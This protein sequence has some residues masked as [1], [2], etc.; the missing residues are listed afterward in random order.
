M[1]K[2]KILTKITKC[3]QNVFYVYEYSGYVQR[4]KVKKIT[5][6][7]SNKIDEKVIKTDFDKY[8]G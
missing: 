1:P 5:R 6:K 8:F 2:F 7:R 4:L 3:A